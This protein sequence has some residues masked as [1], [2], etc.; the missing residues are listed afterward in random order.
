MN[1]LEVLTMYQEF[2]HNEGRKAADKF[3]VDIGV[4][5]PHWHIQKCFDDW[6]CS[7]QA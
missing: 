1:L 7:T 6:G 2:L 4:E 5:F 3:L